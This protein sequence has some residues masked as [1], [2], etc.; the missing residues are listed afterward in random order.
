MG[1]KVT[2]QCM[3]W[4]IAEER[5]AHAHKKGNSCHR[6]PKGLGWRPEAT[7][8]NSTHMENPSEGVDKSRILTLM[9]YL[10]Q[11]MWIQKDW[12]QECLVRA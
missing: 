7:A 2:K 1:G 12:E 8:P 3:L 9:Q 4:P 10:P 11:V 5:Q 6:T